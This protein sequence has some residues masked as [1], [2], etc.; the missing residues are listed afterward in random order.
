MKRWLISKFITPKRV[1]SAVACFISW[2]MHYAIAKGTWSS[3]LDVARWMRKLASFIES[4]D[5]S[6]LPADKDRLLADLVG[7]AITDEA[8]DKLVDCVSAMKA[9]AAKQ[10]AGTIAPASGN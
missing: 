6:D 7:E 9:E 8:V 3:V 4:W 1:R 2:L 5:A 10:S